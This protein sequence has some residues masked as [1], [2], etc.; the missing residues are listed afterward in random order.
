[1]AVKGG[2]TFYDES[3][4]K[5]RVDLWFADL[6]AETVAT[7]PDQLDIANAG[8]LALLIASCSLCTPVKSDISYEVSKAAQVKPGNVNAQREIGI[9]FT[10]TDNV[11]GSLYHFTIPGG[12][13]ANLLA[14]GTDQVDTS[15]AKFTA[16]KTAFE[17]YCKS[18]VGNAVTLVSGRLVGRNN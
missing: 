5:S 6:T 14:A 13:L 15:K 7:I 11:T 2:V 8:S 12:D 4:E 9:L 1:M 3:G 10:Y 17:T 16:L 18:P